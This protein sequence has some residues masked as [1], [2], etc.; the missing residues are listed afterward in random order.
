[1]MK[2]LSEKECLKKYK[3]ILSSVVYKLKNKST[4]NGHELN[5]YAKNN[6]NNFKG[7]YM[8]NYSKIPKSST[9][10]CYIINTDLVG[11]PGIHWVAIYT[12]GKHYYIYDSFGRQSKKIIPKFVKGGVRFTD[13]DYDAEQKDYETNCGQRALAWLVFRQRYGIHNA[14][15]I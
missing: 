12:T 7:I 4:T 13:S 10:S 2:A 5:I 14:L 9:P 8:Q 15:K 3:S 1:M 6:L 11:G